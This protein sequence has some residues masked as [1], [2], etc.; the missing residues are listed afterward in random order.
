M[1]LSYPHVSLHALKVFVPLILIVIMGS[2]V[3]FRSGTT[4]HAPRVGPLQIPHYLISHQ[5]R[6]LLLLF[7]SLFINCAMLFD[8]WFHYANNYYTICGQVPFSDSMGYMYGAQCLVE[9]GSVDVWAA[10]RPLAS[11]FYAVLL[12]LTEG[13]IATVLLVTCILFGISVYRLA[14]VVTNSFGI[15]AGVLLTLFLSWYHY[16]LIAAP[17]TENVAMIFAN[18]AGALLWSSVVQHSLKRY[19]AGLFTIGLALAIRVGA[20]FAL[21]LIVLFGVALFHGGSR[22]RL[23]MVAALCLLAGGSPFILNGAI[24]HSIAPEEPWLLNGN[25]SYTL[26]GLVN[27][28]KEWQYIY[29]T[30][31]ELF[32]GTIPD[33]EISRRIYWYTLQEFKTHPYVFFTALSKIYLQ[34]GRKLFNICM[35]FDFFVNIHI[36]FIPWLIGSMS[37]GMFGSK[38]VEMRSLQLCML[39]ALGVLLS[40]PVVK[41][42]G[43]RAIAVTVPFTCLLTAAGTGILLKLLRNRNNKGIY[44]TRAVVSVERGWLDVYMVSMLT[45]L[46][47]IGP[48]WLK[49]TC[50]KNN[51]RATTAQNHAN[52]IVFRVQK[53]ASI[54]I[55]PDGAPAHKRRTV[56]LG[57]YHA[58]NAI[59]ADQPEF[60]LVHPGNSIFSA[61]YNLADPT[62]PCHYLCLDKDI[63]QF[64]GSIAQCSVEKRGALWFGKNITI[65]DKN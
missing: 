25:L 28:D 4:T 48:F 17:M 34:A 59:R 8:F 53:G 50:K 9:H 42:A 15:S 43:F 18:F 38:R 5:S 11:C 29:T 49:M 55:A 52:T 7:F 3:F 26:Y 30:H 41:S 19:L 35:P 31:P 32:E 65:L 20:L 40:W 23:L 1:W 13:N 27:G 46:L 14:K 44:L 47:V 51:Y 64:A 6:N 45:L 56:P 10:R 58:A 33:G 37:P 54:V 62:R 2:E 60:N 61:V 21:P 63:E 36:F 22:K 57:Y 39:I 16:P 12:K 24:A